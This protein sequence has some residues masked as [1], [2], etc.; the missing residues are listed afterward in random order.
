MYQ[1]VEALREEVH[2][3]EQKMKNYLGHDLGPGP[4]A[5]LLEHLHKHEQ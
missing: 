5:L 2:N 3:A 4:G 1:E